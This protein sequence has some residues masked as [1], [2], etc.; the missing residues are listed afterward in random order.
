MLVFLLL[1]TL[2]VPTV[3]SD[4]PV[5]CLRHQISG[6]WE[7]TLTMPKS[8]RGSCGHLRPDSEE[9]Q[10][11]V[12]FMAT[13][14]T[15]KKRFHLQDPDVVRDGDRVGTWTMVYDEG[16]E[17]AVGEF[18]YFAFSRFELVPDN[19]A[20][21][22]HRNIS[23]CDETQVGWYHDKARQQ[24]GC[25]VGKK[26]N[27][28]K[29]PQAALA[30]TRS[31]QFSWETSADNGKEANRRSISSSMSAHVGTLL[32][33]VDSHG[34]DAPLSEAWHKNVADALNLLQLSWKARVYRHLVNRTARDM[35]KNAGLRRNI[36]RQS[37][38]PH[39]AKAFLEIVEDVPTSFDWS[40]KDGHSYLDDVITQGD[41]GSCYSISTLRMMSA[42]NRVRAG[43]PKLPPFSIT[44]PLYCSEYNQGCG[45][46]YGFLE[47]KWSEDV[48]LIPETCAPYNQIGTCQLDSKCD[49]GAKRYRAANHRYVGGFYGAT[50]SKLVASELIAGGPLVMSFEPKEDFMYYEKGVY[51]SVPN[52]IHQEWE[53]VD[54][55]V[56]LVG[57]G[58]DNG[59]KYW[60]LQ[61]SWGTDWGENGYF[62]MI[63]GQDESGCESIV[64]AAEVVEESKN[65]VL[66]D[67]LASVDIAPT[68]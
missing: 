22:G 28:T 43:N 57:F 44:F 13:L 34:Y 68:N 24:W 29:A 33:D 45:G 30:Q 9:R 12:D 19:F 37:K 32:L 6:E 15:S 4:L 54:H 63:R 18:T 59:K 10:P 26:V 1:G 38:N 61:N 65:P 8:K 52:K 50:D 3:L 14:Q 35:N 36:P 39:K 46:G 11:A 25:Y 42:R 60:L 53:Q 5:H 17:V 2:H 41:C 49:L 48:G 67:F 16:F 51:E 20:P 47:S 66:D 21:D 31:H 27:V 55:A 62:R 23:H 64:V 7:F 58:E 40:N 56:L